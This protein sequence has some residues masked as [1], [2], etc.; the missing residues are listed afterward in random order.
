MDAKSALMREKTFTELG[1]PVTDN[2]TSYINQGYT[3]YSFLND[4]END[5]AHLNDTGYKI[6]ADEVYKKMIELGYCMAE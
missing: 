4:P 6:V 3:A 1:I 2:D 5:K